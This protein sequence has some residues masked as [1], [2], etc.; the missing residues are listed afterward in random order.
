MAKKQEDLQEPKLRQLIESMSDRELRDAVQ[1]MQDTLDRLDGEVEAVTKRT[2]MSQEQLQ[3]FVENPSNF[4]REEWD[5]LQRAKQV[6][7]EFHTNMWKAFGKDPSVEQKKSEE[8]KAKK[9]K[10]RLLGATKKNWIP[11]S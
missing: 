3:Q 10:R 6:V 7:E 4:S 5:Q 8:M 1:E 2:G 11:M 9:Q